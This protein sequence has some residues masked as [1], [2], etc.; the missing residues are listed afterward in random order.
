[1]TKFYLE[2]DKT[3][4]ALANRVLNEAHVLGNEPTRLI[5]PKKGAFFAQSLTITA[6]DSNSQPITLVKGAHFHPVEILHKVTQHLGKE[7]CLAILIIDET[8]LGPASINYQALGGEENVGAADLN[9]ALQAL[10]QSQTVQWVNLDHPPEFVAKAHLHD[11]ADLYGMEFVTEAIRTVRTAITKGDEVFHRQLLERDLPRLESGFFD[12]FNVAQ[13][14]NVDLVAKM[15]DRSEQ[16]FRLLSRL[17]GEIAA[18]NTTTEEIND[19]TLRAADRFE[20]KHRDMFRSIALMRLSDELGQKQNKTFG[21]PGYID[22][23]DFWVDFTHDAHN[24]V[25]GGVL[26]SDD[27]SV[28]GRIIVEI[29]RAAI[30]AVQRVQSASLGHKVLRLTDKQLLEITGPALN[31]PVDATVIAVVARPNADFSRTNLLSNLSYSI[32]HNLAADTLLEFVGPDG[33]EAH[34]PS[35]LYDNHVAH[36]IMSS[37]TSGIGDSLCWSNSPPSN[38]RGHN[39]FTSKPKLSRTRTLHRIGSDEEMQNADIAEIMVYSRRL[40]KYELDAISTYVENKYGL[41]TTL[42]VNG[43]FSNGLG[44]FQTDYELSVDAGSEGK[45]AVLHKEAIG[46]QTGFF[47]RFYTVP[48]FEAITRIMPEGNQFLAV[49]T[50]RSTHRAFWIQKQQL[51]ANVRHELTLSI[52][53][54]PSNPPNL[55]LE[56]DGVPLDISVVLPSDRTKVDNAK[57]FFTPLRDDVTLR[58]VNKNVSG[59][60][61]TFGVDNLRLRRCV[62]S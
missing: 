2:L 40:S 39:G 58:L 50:S 8:I 24:R 46:S 53:Y 56:V 14:Q 61:N 25:V 5:I 34:A 17:D 21:V 44:E 33:V 57:I 15:F 38:Y 51:D 1:M 55:S 41:Q 47:S 6:Q 48:N 62:I 23:L 59:P 54:N 43:N 32:K 20:L 29:Q 42:I 36:V 49:N 60:I 18:F 35:C 30:P 37:I 12:A 45:L 10:S 28:H 52:L 19:Y 26:Q 9:A 31:V 11:S 16:A 27:L 13:F 7:V 22:N 3:G 4:S